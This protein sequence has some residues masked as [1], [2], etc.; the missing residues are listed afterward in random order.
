MGRTFNKSWGNV[1]YE[2]LDE[3]A[4]KRYW[5]GRKPSTKMALEEWLGDSDKTQR[6]VEEEYGKKYRSI[7][8]N[9]IQ[10][11]KLEIIRRFKRED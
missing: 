1:S 8:L 11:M 10:L 4:Y 3:E 5:W 6:Q 2:I 9:M 7:N